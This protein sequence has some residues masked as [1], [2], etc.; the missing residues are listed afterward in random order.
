[1]ST[2]L[3]SLQMLVPAAAAVHFRGVAS[4]RT[5]LQQLATTAA[6]AACLTCSPPA[7]AVSGGGK[8][9]SGLALEGADFTSQMLRG[10]EFRGIRGEGAIFRGANLASTSFFKADLTK[11]DFT[12]A[13]LSSASL[14]EAGLDGADFSNANLQSAY[15]T[16]T[17]A[18][19][20]SIKGADFSEAIM[21]SYTQKMLCTRSDAT[22]ENAKTGMATRDSLMCP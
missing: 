8:D 3:L 14:E 18:D 10:K 19:A 11:A 21:P 15:L 6:L 9:Y 7:F 4:P 22:G 2:A 12:G 16:K 13:D 17:I 5:S 1:M 20:V